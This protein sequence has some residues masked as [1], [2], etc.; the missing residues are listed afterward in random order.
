MR[1]TSITDANESGWQCEHVLLFG[2]E[3][4]LDVYLTNTDVSERDAESSVH[5][6]SENTSLHRRHEC[7]TTN[8]LISFPVNGDSDRERQREKERLIRQRFHRGDSSHRVR[9]TKK[10]VRTKE[11]CRFNGSTSAD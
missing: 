11:N 10:K 4:M 5:I 6:M 7:R 8:A 1:R 2:F 9:G 3:E